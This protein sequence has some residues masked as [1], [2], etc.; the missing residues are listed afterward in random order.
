MQPSPEHVRVVIVGA[1]FAGLGALIRLKQEGHEDVRVLERAD[2]VGGVW[3]ANRYPGAACDVESH[4]YALSFAPNPGWSRRFAGGAEI[5][6]YLQGLVER[7]GLAP[8]LR[9]GEEVTEA[10]WDAARARWRLVTTAGAMTADVLVAAPGALSEPRLPDLPGRDAF[11]GQAFHTAAWPDGLDLRGRRVA[12]IG[13]GAS[14]VQVIPAIQPFVRRLTVFQ[15][16]PVWVLPRRDRRIPGRLRR[17]FARVP[18]VRAALRLRLYAWHELLGL[19][20]RHPALM[21]PVE[22]YCRA[23]LRWHV[24]DPALRRAL[25]PT[26]RFGCKRLMLSDDYYPALVQPNVE[27]VPGGAVAVRPG[28]VVGADGAERPA[29]VVVYAT[30]FHV[31][32]FPFAAQVF[33][34]EGVSL[35]TRW[36]GR[37]Q[38][39]LGTTV[40]G[41][42]N[43]FLLGGPNTGLGHSSVLMMFEAQIEH[44]V[45]ALAH[46]DATGA[47]AL[48]PLAAAQA[49]FVAEMDRASAGT[50]WVAGGCASWYLDAEGRNAALWPYGVGAFRR[51][52]ACFRPEPYRFL[53]QP[54]PVD[55]VPA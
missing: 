30:G 41:Y 35:A 39:F 43:L 24:K 2:A 13:T 44:L 37:P 9:L 15:R 6:R 28:G 16:T 14:A 8:H 25:T 31:T 23:Y 10:R 54:A 21:T 19:P 5:W 3:R 55:A 53:P 40:A 20:F 48:E 27:V 26:Y 34:A 42:P 52:V 45:G 1:G 47:A 50:V 22:A 36:A 4:L 33:D 38:A 49:A 51:R 46:L 18:G 17:L 11:A 7:F 29:D 32:D 12:V